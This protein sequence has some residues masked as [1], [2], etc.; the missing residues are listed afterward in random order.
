MCVTL[1][2]SER[3]LFVTLSGAA[4]RRSRRANNE[5]NVKVF[6]V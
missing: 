1:I 2:L 3:T 5:S 4:K 6:T